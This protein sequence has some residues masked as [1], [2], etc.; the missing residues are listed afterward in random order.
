MNLRITPFVIALAISLA[1]ALP[2]VAGA[3]MPRAV[4][5]DNPSWADA[6]L[7]TCGGERESPLAEPGSLRDNGVVV[8]LAAEIPEPGTY[9][10]MLAGLAL[11]VVAARR[12]RRR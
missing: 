3:A 4:S 5:C 7:G 11:V 10:L 8:P 9:A 1:S 2:G 12:A 6:V